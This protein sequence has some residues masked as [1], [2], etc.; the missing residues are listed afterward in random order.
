MVL[1]PLQVAPQ[2]IREIIV[3]ASVSRGEVEFPLLEIFQH[4][5]TD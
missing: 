4:Y 1:A 3:Q 5:R 2:P